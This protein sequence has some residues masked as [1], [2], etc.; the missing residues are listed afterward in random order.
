MEFEGGE[1]VEIHTHAAMEFEGGERE[2]GGLKLLKGGV[3][4]H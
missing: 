1:G 4:C 2:L 3:G